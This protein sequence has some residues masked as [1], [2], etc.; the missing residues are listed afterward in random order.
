M[1]T[2]AGGAGAGVARFYLVVACRGLHRGEP[3]NEAAVYTC[4]HDGLTRRVRII[5][6]A[7][8]CIT[9]RTTAPEL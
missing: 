4:I 3:S 5:R 7:P 8:E 9:R 1:A 6:T 2:E